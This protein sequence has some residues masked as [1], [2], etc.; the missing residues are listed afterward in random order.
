MGLRVIMERVHKVI[1][2]SGQTMRIREARVTDIGLI[3]KLFTL[4]YQN[5][6]PLEFGMNSQILQAE[7]AD[8]ERYLWLV[9]E[10]GDSSTQTELVGGTLFHIDHLNRL[11]KAAGSIVD[12][13]FRKQGLGATFL[14]LGVDYLTAQTHQ[15]DVLYSTT[16]TVNIAPSKMVAE[17]GFRPMGIFPNAIQIESLENLNLD[18]YI[19]DRALQVRR[20]KPYLFGPFY[21][22][23]TIARDQLSLEPAT[24]VTERAPLKLSRH[25]ISLKL[26]EDVQ[27][28]IARFRF[29]TEQKRLSNSF[30]PFHSPNWCFESEDKG[31]EVFVW[32]GGV[33]KQASILGYRTDRVNIHDLLDSVAFALQ[34]AGAAYVE[35][36]VD[37]YDYRLQQEA[38]TARFIP[39]GYFPALQLAGDGLRDDYFVLS[40][41]FRLLDFTNCIV[42][43]DH[44]KFLQI[45]L[46]CYRD[47]YIAPLLG[48]AVPPLLS[49]GLFTS[50]SIS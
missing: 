26:I 15:I 18:V 33:G 31:T 47:L 41:T 4:I 1:D 36:L 5:K 7:I 10:R 49:D 50:A 30:F 45:Y 20:N 42:A 14:K 13:S 11:G 3:Q 38:Y 39:S 48:Q 32:Y 46:R 9:A 21:D 44:F 6:Y 34:N 22:V 28:V 27:E 2:I 23:Y 16:R 19:T 12:P 24:L 40:R 43:G 35:L 37:A 29:Y 25:K 17:A 8:T